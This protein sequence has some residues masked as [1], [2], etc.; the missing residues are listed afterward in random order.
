MN[1]GGLAKASGRLRYT[2]SFNEVDFGDIKDKDLEAPIVVIRNV[3]AIRRQAALN[4]K[5]DTKKK[6]ILRR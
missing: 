3:R 6:N 1:H 5:K 4:S 2:L